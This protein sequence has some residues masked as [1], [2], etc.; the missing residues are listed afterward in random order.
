N[1]ILTR[2]DIPRATGLVDPS[3][4]FNPG[5]V[6]FEGRVLLMLRVQA[7]SRATSFVMASSLDGRR[8][9][10]AE[11]TVTF[12]G[13]EA[14]TRELF[15]LYDAR[16]TCLTDETGGLE[17]VVI[18]AADMHDA[19][20]LGVARTRDFESF[21]FLGFTEE[22]ARNGVLF[23]EKFG[24]QY[25]RLERPNTVRDAGGVATGDAVRLSSSPDLV[26]WTPLERPLILAGRPR[27]WDE[28]I[29]SGPPPV[30]TRHG[31]LHLYHGVATHFASANIY[32]AGAVLLDLDDPSKVLGR[33]WENLLE[34]REP[35]ELTGQVPNVVFPSGMVVRG[36]AP[37]GVAA[38]GDEL[39]V[40]YGAADTSV[41]L[42][43][44]RIGDL[45]AACLPV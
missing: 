33:T 10:V 43:S 45:V 42:C 30:K 24:D 25:L 26:H 23:P 8:F 15:H 17:G 6:E 14:E 2:E 19:C 41:G 4:V 20:R 22:P 3:S 38:D 13:L 12:E 5:A 28:L 18:F 7:R 35:Y 36:L 27:Y 16:L 37:G 29:G 1:P 11:K 32:Q 39:L 34:P 9:D 44:A 31:W 21:E 40:Y